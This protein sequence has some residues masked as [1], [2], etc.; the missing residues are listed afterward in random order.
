MRDYEGCSD[1]NCILRLVPLRQYTNGGSRSLERSA[2]LSKSGTRLLRRS[3]S[4]GR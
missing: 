4:C 3:S 1:G 2:L